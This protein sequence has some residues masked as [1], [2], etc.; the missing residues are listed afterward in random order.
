MYKDIF[1]AELPSAIPPD[2]KLGDEHAI[3]LVLD[4]KPVHKPMYRHSP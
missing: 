4:A 2:R 3:P 1:P